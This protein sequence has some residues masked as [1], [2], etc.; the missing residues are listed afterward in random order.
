MFHKESLIGSLVRVSMFVYLLSVSLSTWLPLSI[1]TDI[2]LYLLLTARRL[3]P[4]HQAEG[5]RT[6]QQELAILTA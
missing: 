4:M 3:A 6:R 1:Y 2:Y 5:V